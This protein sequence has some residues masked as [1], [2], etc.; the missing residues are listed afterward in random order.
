MFPMKSM[1]PLMK[2]PSR[3]WSILLPFVAWGMI[4]SPSPV[5]TEIIASDDFSQYPEGRPPE[6]FGGKGWQG[7]WHVGAE[8][9]AVIEMAEGP[10]GVPKKC[11]HIAGGNTVR[12]LIRRIAE[13]AKYAGQAV[14]LRVDFQ[15]NNP[16][17]D[18]A[19]VFA[20]WM[21]ADERSHRA[22]LPGV[23]TSLQRPPSVR[24]GDQSK[25]L[26]VRLTPEKH[27][28]LIG[29]LGGWDEAAKAYSEVT[30][31]L[32]PEEGSLEAGQ[33]REA[34]LSGPP[35]AKMF[36]LLFLRTHDLGEGFYRFFEVRLSTSWEEA[37]RNP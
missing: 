2:T 8:T 30:L 12:A 28:T 21:F 11:L 5:R 23:T 36:E 1:F 4:L 24:L 34:Q 37:L 6:T 18:S 15:V 31:W 3:L 9:Q 35:D 17:A 14:Y 22:N 10:D 25:N 32:D 27:H 7:K 33:P 19:D 13:P 26:A 20:N 29:K 16:K